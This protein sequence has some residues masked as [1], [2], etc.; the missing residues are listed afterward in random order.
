MRYELTGRMSF[1][2]H[3]RNL[4]ADRLEVGDRAAELDAFLGIA[5]GMVERGLRQADRAGSGMGPRKAEPLRRVLES[6]AEVGV[7]PN[8]RARALE[9]KF[10]GLPAKIT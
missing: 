2:G 3:R 1:G 5:D 9:A 10:P 4:E 7:W 8:R 6:P